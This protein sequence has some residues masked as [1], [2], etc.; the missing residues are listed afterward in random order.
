MSVIVELPAVS[1]CMLVHGGYPLHIRGYR[2]LGSVP[3]CWRQVTLIPKGP[4]SSSVVN[5]RPI[6]ITSVLS[7]VFERQVS[8]RSGRF[9]ERIVVLPTTQFAYRKGLGTSDALCA[10]PIHCREH[11]RVGTRL[12]LCRLISVQPLIGSIIRTFSISSALWVLKVL[13]C[14][15]ILFQSNGSQHVMVDA[16]WR[17]LLN[18]LSRTH[19]CLHI[20]IPQCQETK[21]GGFRK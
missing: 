16:G 20:G 1:Y 3:A 8:V 4:P 18:P 2:P 12:G 19:N 17:K 7:K 9:M 15:L 11:W 5:Y 10:C 14:L 6:S 21:Y 13:C